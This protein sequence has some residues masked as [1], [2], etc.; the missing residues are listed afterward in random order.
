LSEY[1]TTP[2]QDK[3]QF[4]QTIAREYEKGVRTII[5]E[6]A[7]NSVVVERIAATST[8]TPDLTQKEIRLVTILRRIRNVPF[9]HFV[10]VDLVKP[11]FRAIRKVR[12]WIK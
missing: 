1:F 5:Q 11:I 3:W 9:F 4:A 8:L 7:S 10:Y 2:P 6:R 12:R